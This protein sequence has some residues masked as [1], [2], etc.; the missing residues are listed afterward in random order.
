MFAVLLSA[1]GT[2]HRGLLPER[3]RH[4]ALGAR[5]NAPPTVASPSASEALYLTVPLDYAK[6]DGDHFKVRYFVDA[7]A[8][9]AA[10]G[11]APIF[12]SMGGEGTTSGAHCSSL[13]QRHRA[14]CVSVEHRFYGESL[15]S[16]GATDANYWA[17]L[18]VEANLADTAGVVAALQ[19]R[20]PPADASASRRSVVAFGGSYSGATCAWFRQSYPHVVDGCVSSSGVVNAILDFPQFDEHVA[21]A[22]G[23][24]CAAALS[25]A[26]AAVDRA[27]D[28]GRGAALKKQFNASNLVGTTMGDSDFMYAIADGPAMLDQ[29]GSK[30]EL[31]DGL[32]ALP[33]SPSDDERIANLGA[34]IAHHYGTDFSSDCF[35]DSECVANA[36]A[37]PQD[38]PSALGGLNSRSWRFQKCSE[39]AFLQAQPKAAASALPPLRSAKLTIDELRAQCEYI[40]PQSTP[41]LTERNAALNARFGR[42]MPALGS[43]GATEIF[44]LDFSDDP[45]AEA[46]VRRSTTSTLPFCMTTCDGCGHCGAGVPSSEREC[47]EQSDQFVDALLAK[48]ERVRAAD[49]AFLATYWRRHATNTTRWVGRVPRRVGSRASGEVNWV[50]AGAVTTPTSQGR[51][52]TCQ[53]FSCIADVEGAWFTSGHPLIKLSEQQMIDCA[54]GDQYGMGW[55]VSNGG[56]ASIEDAP[57]ADHSD[58][59][60]TGCRGVTDCPAVAPKVAAYINGSTVRTLAWSATSS[61]STTSRVTRAFASRALPQCLTNHDEPNILAMLQHGPMSVS[62]NAGPLNGYHGGVI[63]C[64]GTGIDHAVTLV[65]YGVNKT[66]GEGWWTIKNS[67]GP[68]FG[69]SSPPGK[70]CPGEKGYAR[71]KYGNT[72][73]RGPCQAFVGQAPPWERS[74]KASST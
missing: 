50:S 56:V 62:I 58:P 52:G 18:A 31:C 33:A 72:C 71:L 17:G 2:F 73:L 63:D 32:A 42:D 1:V 55:I 49:A 23:P 61:P 47:F 5:F 68:D 15:P 14:L 67:W 7:S 6:P 9:D 16:T 74:R 29:Y 66:T 70:T 41:R 53:D 12:V 54:G 57:L 8:F 27:F 45:W 34:V 37:P 38:K 46:S 40:F 69:E 13:A 60:I 25:A 28:A 64:V 43:A 4:G 10:S 36:T 48:R 11:D 3:A 44:Y 24:D 51:C 26:Y 22:I 59:N 30:K 35:Y 65:A 19:A 20:Y 39:V 21:A